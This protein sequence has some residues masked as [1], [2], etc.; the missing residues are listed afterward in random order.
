MPQHAF[1]ET[2]LRTA[3]TDALKCALRAWLSFAAMVAGALLLAA[4]GGGGTVPFQGVQPRALSAEFGNRA[5]VNYSPFRSAQRNPADITDD[6]VLE[7]LRLLQAAGLT[8]LRT[9]DSTDEVSGRLLRLIQTQG[10]DFKVMLGVWIAPNQ[11]AANQAEIDRGVALATQYAGTVLAVSVGN[12]RMVSWQADKVPVADMVRYIGAVRQRV[13]QPV[14]TDD[15]WLFWSAAPTSVLEAVDFVAMHSY[16]L[17]DSVYDPTSWNWKQTSVPAAQ[18]AEAMMDAALARSKAD[19]AAVKAHLDARGHGSKPVV[20]GETGWKAVASGG[21]SERAHPVN[22]KMMFDRL[23]AWSQQVKAGSVGPRAIFWFE[24]FDEPWKGGDD[25]W[26]LFNVGRQAR[27]VLQSRLA[28]TAQ[29]PWEA[30]SYVASDA[31]YHV[32]LNAGGTVNANRYTV[33]AETVTVGEARPAVATAWNAWENGST[34]AAADL[35]AADS[36]DPS[37]A[38]RITP[39]PAAW[40]WGMALTLPASAEDLSQFAQ[41]NLHFSIR[42]TYPG[43]IEVGFLTGTSSDATL[44]DVYRAIASGEYGYVNDGTWRQVSIPVADLVSR[45]APAFGMA[46][47]VTLNLAQVTNPFV[48]ADRYGVTGKVQGSNVTTP[49]DIDRVYWTRD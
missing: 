6:M 39:T 21:E 20:I 13:T 15:S 30:G 22:Q 24:A 45:G 43:K 37:V 2:V 34:S 35:P 28:N 9:F 42:T 25:K 31:L 36:P 48:V 38:V 10:L 32:P 26:G 17:L 47:T 18:R 40:G 44:Y 3:P 41:G 14:T 33:F 27:H 4:C 7:D 46:G 11:E 1:P 49:I 16:P 5:A 29:T 8:L 19:Y 23:A 12:E